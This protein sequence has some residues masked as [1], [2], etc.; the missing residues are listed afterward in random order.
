MG[1]K[2]VW[3][4]ARR[5]GRMPGWAFRSQAGA[6]I[7]TRNSVTLGRVYGALKPYRD[8]ATSIALTGLDLPVSRFPNRGSVR[9]N[10][11]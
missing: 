8:R 9:A 3:V 4:R 7:T 10:S 6:R 2:M 1:C 5:V 11:S